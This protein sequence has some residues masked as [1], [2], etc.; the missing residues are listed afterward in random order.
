MQ[1]DIFTDRL[2]GWIDCC[3]NCPLSAEFNKPTMQTRRTVDLPVDEKMSFVAPNL[4]AIW[5]L[6]SR[7][8]VDCDINEMTCEFQILMPCNISRRYNSEE[9]ATVQQMSTERISGLEEILFSNPD[10]RVSGDR[11]LNTLCDCA[12]SLASRIKCN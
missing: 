8:S 11:L 10:S 6:E 9:W 4:N 3:D 1:L 7:H 12:R 2:N 5:T